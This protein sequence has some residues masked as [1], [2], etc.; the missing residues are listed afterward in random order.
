M[1][2]GQEV[3]IEVA[4]LAGAQVALAFQ[5]EAARPLERRCLLLGPPHLIDGLVQQLH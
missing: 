2:T 3:L 5:P 4:L 1:R